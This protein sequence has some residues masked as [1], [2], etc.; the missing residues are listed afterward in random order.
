MAW[1]ADGSTASAVFYTT[2]SGQYYYNY[3]VDGEPETDFDFSQPGEQIAANK[4]TTIN[5]WNLDSSKKYKLYIRLKADD[6]TYSVPF[7]FIFE[8]LS[9]TPTPIP[10]VSVTPTTAPTRDPKVPSVSESKVTGLET[11]LEFYP[12]QFYPFTV[13]GAGSDNTSPIKGD[14]KWVPLYWSTSSNPSDSDKHTSW[15]IGVETGGITQAA[16]FNMYVFYQRYEHNGTNWVATDTISSVKYPFYSAA[17]TITPSPTGTADEDDLET[18]TGT[19][20]GS[21]GGYYDSSGNYVSYQQSGSTSAVSYEDEASTERLAVATADH[22]PVGT[23]LSMLMLSMIT[24]GF[25]LIRKN[26]KVS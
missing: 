19:A 9:V 13:V 2:K 24:A 20:S 12:G 23:F 10:E 4:N 15:K 21:S 26:K 7:Y 6:G 11:A 25:V 8:P 18:G 14:V 17:I 1:G 5:L 3:V 16:T 22:T